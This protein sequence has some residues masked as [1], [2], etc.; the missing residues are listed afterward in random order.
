MPKFRSKPRVITAEQFEL[1]KKLPAKIRLSPNVS[2]SP[3]YEVWNGLHSS[4]IKLKP[5]D[6]VRIDDPNDNY[7]IDQE[8]FHNTYEPIEG[9]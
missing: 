2:T 5:G 4:W 7:P 3:V 6:Y 1:G 9:D 8:T